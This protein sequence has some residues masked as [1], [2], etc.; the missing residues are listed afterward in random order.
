MEK[1]TQKWPKLS[2]LKIPDTGS[3]L[4]D[5]DSTETA[6][7]KSVDAVL[8]ESGIGGLGG[9]L[10]LGWFNRWTNFKWCLLFS[11]L[12]VFVYG[13]AGLVCAFMTWFRSACLVLIL[14][15]HSSH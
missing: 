1:F 15:L 6:L 10:G 7:R 14:S 4:D 8:L 5:L 13:T 12:S 9:V 11:V 2:P 3:S